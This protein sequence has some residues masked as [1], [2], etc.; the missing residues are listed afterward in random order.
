[1]IPIQE[2]DTYSDNEIK[3]SAH[4]V[5]PKQHIAA[6][7]AMI[8]DPSLNALYSAYQTIGQYGSAIDAFVAVIDMSSRYISKS[9]GSI[10]RVNNPCN[11]EFV[12]KA[13][14]QKIVDGKQIKVQVE[15]N[16]Q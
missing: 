15:V 5:V 11:A 13:E 1:M 7:E 9:G 2:V 4:L 6:C 3:I 16:G 8:Y 10:T 14:Q 12:G